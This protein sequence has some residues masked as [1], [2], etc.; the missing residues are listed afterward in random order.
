MAAEA[1]AAAPIWPQDGPH[2][3]KAEP[4]EIVYEIIVNLPDAGLLPGLVPDAPDKP[5]APPPNNDTTP[6]TSP[7]QYPAVM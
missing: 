4:D 3:V 1:A 7:R 6:A 5:I 2:L